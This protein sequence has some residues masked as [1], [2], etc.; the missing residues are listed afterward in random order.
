[1]GKLERGDKIFYETAEI[2]GITEDRITINCKVCGEDSEFTRIA[3]D[4]GNVNMCIKCK[5]GATAKKAQKLMR[6]A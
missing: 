4:N 5:Y 3:Y 6:E 1:M 2:I